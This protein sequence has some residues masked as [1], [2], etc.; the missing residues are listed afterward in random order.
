MGKDSDCPALL[1]Y[2][3]AKTGKTTKT[4]EIPKNP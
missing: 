4:D 3:H 1:S 2:M